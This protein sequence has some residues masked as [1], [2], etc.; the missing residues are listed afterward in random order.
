MVIIISAATFISTLL[1]GFFALKFRNKL[2]LVLG[3]SAGAMIGVAFFDLLPAAIEL[4]SRA[5]NIRTV[6][7]TA[8]MGCMFYL[9]L[10]RMSVVFSNKNKVSKSW[11]LRGKIAALCLTFHSLID[12]IAIG[13]AFQVS[14][15]TGSMIA[16]AILV[17]DFADGINTANA[18]LKENGRKKNVVTWVLINGLAPVVGA[19]STLYYHISQ[20]KL[21][22]LLALISGFFLY[23]GASDFL[24]ES[25]KL[26]PRFSTTLMTILGILI[27]FL[28][29]QISG[30]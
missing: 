2:Y 30:I 6:T 1:G 4:A 25:Q 19:L 21:G 16:A 7:A 13:I 22:I 26:Y 24:P 15:I 5:Y 9:G 11:T 20:E 27:L 23:I 3:F 12:G 8:G 29:V 18:I 14:P 10:D 28:A 17:H